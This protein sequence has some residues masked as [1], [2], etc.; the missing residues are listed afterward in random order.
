VKIIHERLD[1][2]DERLS[3]YSIN[4]RRKNGMERIERRWLN[5]KQ[6]AEYCGYDSPNHFRKLAQDYDVPRHGPHG[7]RYD[8]YELDE[9]MVNPR[10]FADRNSAIIG[11]RK[12]ARF[13][14]IRLQVLKDAQWIS[15]LPD[16]DHLLPDLSEPT[17]E[18]LLELRKKQAIYKF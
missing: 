13:T 3:C 4:S 1:R 16:N 10:S 15:G 2:H 5:V 6:A 18:E 14:P 9:W 12:L 7:N 8:K 11:S 17:W